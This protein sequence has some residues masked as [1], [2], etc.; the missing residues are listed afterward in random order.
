MN[1]NYNQDNY[2]LN[3]DTLKQ[4]EN[5]S[6]FETQVEKAQKMDSFQQYIEFKNVQ[7]RIHF[8]KKLY[9]LLTIKFFINLGMIALGLYTENAKL[10]CEYEFRLLVT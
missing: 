5:P 6:L 10:V 1:K 8:L 9:F 2:L 4:Y 7:V 3:K